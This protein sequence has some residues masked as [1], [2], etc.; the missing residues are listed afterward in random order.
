LAQSPAVQALEGSAKHMRS[1]GEAADSGDVAG[2][3]KAAQ[4]A[5]ALLEG[6]QQQLARAAAG[7]EQRQLAQERKS[8]LDQLSILRDGQRSLLD[9]TEKL[10]QQVSPDGSFT[11]PVRDAAASVSVQQGELAQSA[12]GMARRLESIS[13]FEYVLGRAAS[14]MEL[15]ARQLAERG[16]VSAATR[17]QQAAVVRL[18]QV[19][20]ALAEDAAP[21]PGTGNQSSETASEQE[22]TPKY[23][24]AELKVLRAWQLEINRRTGEIDAARKSVD[25][26]AELEELAIEQQRL[27]EMVDRLLKTPK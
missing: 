12:S 6:V 18:S 4:D 25:E 16:P 26:Q 22:S 7:A 27:A 21:R 8:L 23:Q 20:D 19:L 9:H 17:A 13:T 11:S 14:D 5:K 3:A 2:A 24:L 15:A 1:A 10:A